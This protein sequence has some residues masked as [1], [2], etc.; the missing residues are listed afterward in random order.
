MESTSFKNITI[1]KYTNTCEIFLKHAH[2]E[3]FIIK[4]IKPNYIIYVS[5]VIIRAFCTA[6][7]LKL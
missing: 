6:G 2:S 3:P 4:L 1:C 5:T 7:E